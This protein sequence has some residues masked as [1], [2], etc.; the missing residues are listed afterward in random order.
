MGSEMCIRDSCFFLY[1]NFLIWM[2][3][4]DDGVALRAQLA[5]S[6]EAGAP[7]VWLG[8]ETSAGTVT[9]HRKYVQILVSAKT[10]K[11]VTGCKAYLTAV[12]RKRPDDT[13]EEIFRDNLLC[14]WSMYDA[15]VTDI[16]PGVPQ[17][18][19]VAS[20]KEALHLLRL[21]PELESIPNALAV[22]MEERG[23]FRFDL[24]ITGADV[25]VPCHICVTVDGS[26]KAVQILSAG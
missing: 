18:L 17:Y 13:W 12:S 14:K 23:I 15:P 19:N 20:A 3:E 1:A 11:A 8:V 9:G 26:G 6:L 24:S 21:R 7:R 25:A 2:A 5:P 4:H 16:M 10:S 22:K